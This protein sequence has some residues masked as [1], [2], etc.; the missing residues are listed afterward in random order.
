MREKLKKLFS[1]KKNN[2]NIEKKATRSLGSIPIDSGSFIEYALGISLN[3]KGYSYLT[4]YQAIN[5]YRKSSPV[6]TA[7]DFISDEIE[8][9]TPVIKLPDGKLTSTHPILDRLRIPNDYETF[10]EFIGQAARFFLVTGNTYFYSGGY[11][12]SPPSMIHVEKSQN[13][14]VTGGINGYPK[15]FQTYEGISNGTYLRERSNNI[16]VRY[17][18]GSLRELYHLKRFSSRDDNIKGDSPLL[19]AALEVGQNILNRVHNVSVLENGGRLSLIVNF[20]DSIHQDEH[21]ERKKSINEQ[22]GGASNAGKIAVTSSTDMDIQEVGKSNKDMDF[23]QLDRVAS[24]SIYNRY[25]IPL[26]LISDDKA[27]FNNMTTSVEYL[28]DFA[29]LPLT[30]KI[31]SALSRMLMHRYKL[32][33]SKFKITYNPEEVSALQTR[34]IDNLTKRKNLGLE[35]IN[36]I[37]EGLPEREP[38]S[39]GDILYQPANLIPVGT[40][41][42]TDDNTTT[43]EEENLARNVVDEE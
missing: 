20:K 16:G 17:Y 1:F 40:D 2:Q 3:I 11:I 30:K 25:K 6:A 31:F 7:V 10:E 35:T 37:R 38:I 41:L 23:Y 36:E 34:L 24:K 22:M 27:T 43:T 33:P 5:F 14:N 26:P 32:D 28:Y 42:Y 21:E 18:D 15:L 29:V 4:D 9:I 19:A 13:V 8:N 39:G 12:N